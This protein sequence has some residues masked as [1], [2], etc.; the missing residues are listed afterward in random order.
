MCVR[1]PATSPAATPPEYHTASEPRPCFLGTDRRPQFRSAECP[2]GEIG[3]DVGAPHDGEQNEDGQHAIRFVLPAQGWSGSTTQSCIRWR[4]C[5]QH[6]LRPRPRDRQTAPST[7]AP[8]AGRSAAP[9][10]THRPAVDNESGR[11]DEE[12]GG[13]DGG[14]IPKPDRAR[15][16][17]IRNS[18]SQSTAM[19]ASNQNSTKT[20]PPNQLVASASDA[21][22]E[23]GNETNCKVGPVG[24]ANI[25][26]LRAHG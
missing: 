10:A 25:R 24:L 5:R 13:D 11:Q 18:H 19:A 3:H 17:L 8:P 12:G 20:G 23:G 9:E 4:G 26:H 14:K 21:H 22:D 16:A 6:G 7:T 2:A 1:L 15:Q